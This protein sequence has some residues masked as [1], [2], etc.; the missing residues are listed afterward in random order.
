MTEFVPAHRPGGGRVFG[1]P[2][3][4][5]G[6]FTSLLLSF[7]SAFFTFFAST[8]IAI[9]SLLGWN[10]LGHHTVNYADSYLFVGFPAGVLVLLIALPVFGT[11]WVRA[12]IRRSAGN[13]DR[14]REAGIER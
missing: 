11:L 7:A 2:L 12:T 13:G 1:F 8:C 6:L 3:E 14:S 9:F 10:V 5:F 4:G